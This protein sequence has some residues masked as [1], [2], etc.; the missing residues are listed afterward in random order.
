MP[1]SKPQIGRMDFIQKAKE[2]ASGQKRPQQAFDSFLNGVNCVL[3]ELDG[4]T[5]IKDREPSG[6]DYV[7]SGT[8]TGCFGWSMRNIEYGKPEANNA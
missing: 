3:A 5:I 6:G 1:K 2:H 7:T 4:K 8:I